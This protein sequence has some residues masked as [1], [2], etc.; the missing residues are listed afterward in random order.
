MNSL[1]TPNSQRSSA[2]KLVKVRRTPNGSKSTSLA[3]NSPNRSSLDKVLVFS[4]GPVG[5]QLEPVK[6]DP[7]YGCRVVRFV[8]GGPMNPGQARKSGNLKPGD[9]VIQVEASG[10]VATSYQDIIQILKDTCVTRTLTFRSVWEAPFLDSQSKLNHLR[11]QPMNSASGKNKDRPSTPNANNFSCFKKQ[12]ISSTAEPPRLPRMLPPPFPVTGTSSSPKPRRVRTRHTLMDITLIQSPSQM[13]LLPHILTHSKKP[14]PRRRQEKAE[15]DGP[16]ILHLDNGREAQKKSTTFCPPSPPKTFKIASTPRESPLDQRFSSPRTLNY[17]ITPD[18]VDEIHES[19]PS[20]SS[21]LTPT[22]SN[23]VS[24]REA[25]VTDPSYAQE[26]SSILSTPAKFS[27]SLEHSQLFSPSGVKKL[28]ETRPIEETGHHAMLYRVFGTVYNSIAP[29]VANSLCAVS[30]VR[31]AG[32]NTIAPVA[33]SSHAIGSKSGEVIAGGSA[34]PDF[35]NTSA[36]KSRVLQELSC[37][38]IAMD[39]QDIAN[40]EIDRSMDELAHAKALLQ[41]DFEAKLDA[42]RLQ[43]VSVY[44]LLV[45]TKSN[46]GLTF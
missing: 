5:L 31:S 35:T 2:K 3:T 24:I 25:N 42:A 36:L 16:M 27:D 7:K 10:T 40:K 23:T 39:V 43:H 29:V 38:K 22:R 14:M 21:R 32:C 6:E 8:D 20:C 46:L 1:G 41:A 44:L 19:A 9:L 15:S 33:S 12:T 37:A 26:D 30:S 4:P 28:S 34:S 17:G 18:Q 45:S 11:L 13:A